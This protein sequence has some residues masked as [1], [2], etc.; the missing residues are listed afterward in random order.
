MLLSGLLQFARRMRCG[1]LFAPLIGKFAVKG[2]KGYVF[3]LSSLAAA[4]CVDAAHELFWLSA[5]F[6]EVIAIEGDDAD[7]EATIF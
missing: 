5:A 3:S 4:G 7:V 1:R 6:I 2:G